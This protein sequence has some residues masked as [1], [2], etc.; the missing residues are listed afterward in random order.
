MAY[1]EDGVKEYI[2]GYALV[3]I[4]FPVDYKGNSDISC[5]R[6]KMFSRS[7]GI[8]RLTNEVSEYPN[9]HVGSNCPLMPISAF[10]EYL[11]AEGVI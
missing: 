6:C 8:C 1:F 2:A 4:H 3:A 9:T 7:A 10:E 5:N 11:K